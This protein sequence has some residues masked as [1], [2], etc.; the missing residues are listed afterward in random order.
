MKNLMVER[1]NFVL[2]GA[3]AIGGAAS[4]GLDKVLRY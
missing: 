3:F 4:K 2:L 1:R